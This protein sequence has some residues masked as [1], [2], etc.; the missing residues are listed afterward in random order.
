MNILLIGNGFDLAHGLPTKYTDFLL[1]C[2]IIF[3][4]VEINKIEGSIPLNNDNNNAEKWLND[5]HMDPF[6][7]LEKMKKIF[8]DECPAELSE[9]DKDVYWNIL[10]DYLIPTFLTTYFTK[11]NNYKLFKEILYLTNRNFWIEYF[12]KNPMYQKEN[13]I[14]FENE[15]SQVIQ[16]FDKDIH[17]LDKNLDRGSGI[18]HLVDK[19]SNR[20]LNEAY[21]KYSHVKKYRHVR[22]ELIFDLNRLIRAFEI[23]LAEF[24]EKIK[25][26]KI[27]PDIREIISFKDAMDMYNNRII[28]FNYTSI[29]WKVYSNCLLGNFEG[30]VVDFIHGKADIN[31]TIETNYM[32]L[33]IDEYLKKKKQNK[34]IDFIAFKK[35][36]QR[37]HKETGYGYK[38]L[39]EEMIQEGQ[40][41]K[42]AI[43][44]CKS[45]VKKNERGAENYKTTL[46]IFAA[47]PPKHHLYIF[48][49]S[50]DVTDKDILKELILTDYVYT[51]IYYR[52][53][54]QK[55]QQIAN[56]VKV[57]GQDELIRRTGGRSARS[58]EFKLQQPMKDIIKQKTYEE[59]DIYSR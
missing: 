10:N 34:E 41:Y 49:H 22:D 12:L 51:T 39:I 5:N 36:Y 9:R 42:N 48:G 21:S 43:S 46:N 58:I 11:E 50:L 33:G 32:V 20:F 14:D 38:D 19:F 17:N 2:K 24:V 26:T 40:K 30:S 4:F 6:L 13:W 18:D 25:I 44:Q 54:E 47:N 59:Y 37:I 1:F 27:S 28:S 31:N 29:Y 57:I 35:Y 7:D 55:G 23:Y 56:L 53:L 16:S 3:K 8:H 52:N 45:K 15:I